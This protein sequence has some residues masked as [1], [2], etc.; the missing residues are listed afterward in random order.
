MD[1]S[2]IHGNV[3]PAVDN[4]YYEMNVQ[5]HNSCPRSMDMPSICGGIHYIHGSGVQQLPCV[6]IIAPPFS[7]TIPKRNF[8][9][10]AVKAGIAFTTAA[11][12]R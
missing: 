5:L 11:V 6:G 12:L 7:I 2:K 1:G 10:L 8:T 3:T 4:L 9:L